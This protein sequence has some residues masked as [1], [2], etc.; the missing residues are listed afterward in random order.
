MGE[1]FEPKIHIL[2]SMYTYDVVKELLINYYKNLEEIPSYTG[3][4]KP[5][6]ESIENNNDKDTSQEPYHSQLS[7][8]LK[9]DK[10]DKYTQKVENIILFYFP[11]FCL[12]QKFC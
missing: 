8:V 12:N 4:V 6:Y 11:I 2:E 1:L 9:P 7:D 5:M 10:N 3:Y